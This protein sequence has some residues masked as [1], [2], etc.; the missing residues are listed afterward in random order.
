MVL[1]W[2]AVTVKF[3]PVRHGHAESDRV[4]IPVHTSRHESGA[5]T[6]G[7]NQGRKLLAIEEDVV[8]CGVYCTQPVPYLVS[9]CAPVKCTVSGSVCVHGDSAIAKTP[10]CPPLLGHLSFVSTLHSLQH[11]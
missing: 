3:L 6:D 11:P 8:L 1:Y 9:V 4:S 5:A 7:S 10:A 2:P